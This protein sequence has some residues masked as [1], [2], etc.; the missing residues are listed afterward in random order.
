MVNIKKKRKIRKFRIKYTRMIW[1]FSV[2]LFI[3][4]LIILFIIHGIHLFTD[5]T[6]EAINILSGFLGIGIIFIIL[7]I[8]R[9]KKRTIK[10]GNQYYSLLAKKFSCIPDKLSLYGYV[11]GYHIKMFS[12]IENH[13]LTTKVIVISNTKDMP[14]AWISTNEKRNISLKKI[15]SGVFNFDAKFKIYCDDQKFINNITTDNFV[16]LL[17]SHANTNKSFEFVIFE[18]RL[19][20]TDYSRNMNS[21][22]DLIFFERIIKLFVNLAEIIDRLKLRKTMRI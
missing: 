12:S 13:K 5:S 4:L 8:F 20:Y 2:L 22:D 18:N 9:N 14:M 1:V 3:L 7:D 17:I 19:H 10:T 16:N 11:Q 6:Q 15:Y 21:I